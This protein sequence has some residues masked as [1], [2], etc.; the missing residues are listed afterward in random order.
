MDQRIEFAMKA[1]SGVSAS[2]VM[3]STPWRNTAPVLAITQTN[4]GRLSCARWCASTKPTP[5]GDRARSASFTA[6]TIKVLSLPVRAASSKYWS[7]P[8]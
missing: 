3:A 8:A 4:C 5:L 7:K 1:L 6:A 2:S